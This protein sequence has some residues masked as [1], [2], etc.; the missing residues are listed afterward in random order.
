MLAQIGNTD[1]TKWIQESTYDMNAEDVYEEWEDGNLH[2]HHSSVRDRVQ[3]SFDLVF[4][5][6]SELDNFITLLNSN[7]TENYVIITVW[8]SNKNAS[9]ECQMFYTFKNT[10]NRQIS[11]DYVYKRFTMTLT[12]R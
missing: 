10:S 12:E 2:K 8:V 6:D 5:T 11:N 3:G 1:I 4:V 9:Q 7:T